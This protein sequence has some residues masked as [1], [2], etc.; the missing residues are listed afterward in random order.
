M[1]FFILYKSFAYSLFESQILC[2]LAFLLS[3]H[4]PRLFFDQ[5]FT[6][7]FI[8]VKQSWLIIGSKKTAPKA[9]FFGFSLN[10]FRD[11]NP[12]RLGSS[13]SVMFRIIGA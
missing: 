4:V 5:C 2:D 7:L 13:Q 3:F 6:T 8:L 10:L 12:F 1:Q 9:S 11:R